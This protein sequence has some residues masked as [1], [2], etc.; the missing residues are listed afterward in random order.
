M[1][2]LM[3]SVLLGMLA[4]S[5][6]KAAAQDKPVVG[7]IPKAQKPIKMDGKLNDWAGAFVR[8]CTSAIRTSPTAVECF[9]SCGMNR[10][11]T[12]DSAASI[13]TELMSPRTRDLERRRSRVLSRYSPWRQIGRRPIRSRHV[14]HVLHGVHEHRDQSADGSSRHAGVQGLQAARGGSRRGKDAIRL[15]RG[16]QTALGELSQ[17]QTQGQ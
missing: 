13:K 4:L 16:I 6:D 15:H 5:A 2:R 17:F 7:V 11:S 14:A 10:T 9:T 8:R 1:K 3:L 12:L